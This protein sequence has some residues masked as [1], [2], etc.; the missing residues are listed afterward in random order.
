[1]NISRFHSEK[2][3]VNQQFVCYY[4]YWNYALFFYLFNA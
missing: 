3:A 2:G 1:M 4:N